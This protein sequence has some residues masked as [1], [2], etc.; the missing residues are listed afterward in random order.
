[1]IK[2]I[3]RIIRGIRYAL[4]GWSFA[5]RND[6]HFRINL[7]L[8][9]LGTVLS[10]LLLSGCK[11]LLI[12]LINYLILVVELI[13]TAIERA[14]DTATDKFH[15]MAKA[16]KDVASSAVLTIGLFAIIVD[17]IFLLPAIIE[18]L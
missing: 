8:S 16:A 7:A 3:K 12:A 15:P 5:L 6:Q 10:L 1:M 14:V 18:K 11:A 17:I 9:L 4:E 2:A 13:N